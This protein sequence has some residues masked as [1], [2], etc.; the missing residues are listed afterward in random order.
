MRLA[1]VVLAR[2]YALFQI[3]DLNP[4]GAVYYPD[5]VNWLVARFGFQKYPTKLEDFDE[6]KGIEFLAGHAGKV[7]VEKMVILNSGV[8]IDT[9]AST[10]ASETILTETLQ[11]AKDE[12]GI[13]FREEMLKRRAY[14]S[15]LAFYSDAPLFQVHPV[16]YKIADIV[17]K[18]VNT[19]FGKVL[20][21]QPVG[22]ALSYDATTTQLG[23]AAFNIQR[24]EGALFTD[25]KYFSV[26][27]TKTQVHM[28]LLEMIERA[29]V[30]TGKSA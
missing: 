7:T 13:Y 8:Y 28:D 10:D 16:F 25:N 3:E 21:Y 19:N 23:P 12:L 14:I 26:A 9:M 4:A 24:R 5:V 18:E 27:P 11:A 30:A 29:A 17:A 22:L 1:S 6:T 15:Q 2:I 20:P